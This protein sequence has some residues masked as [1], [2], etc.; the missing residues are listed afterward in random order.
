MQ[1]DQ[2]NGEFPVSDNPESNQ[3]SYDDEADARD[4]R[5]FQVADH[6]IA[7]SPVPPAPARPAHAASSAGAGAAA[8]ANAAAA[9]SSDDDHFTLR[10]FFLWCGVPV[11]IVLLIRIFAVGFY[12]IPSRSMMDTMVPGD[13]VV[14]SKLTPK[15][16]DLQRG[17]VVVFKDPNNWLNEE[18]SS[19]PGGGYL[20][21]RLIGLPGDVVECKGAGQP[22]TINGVA[23]NETSYIRPGVDPSAF[24]FSVTVTEGHVFVMGDNRANS[25]DSRYHQDDG[26]RGLVPISD[27]VESESRNTGRLTG[28][29]RLM[30]TTKSSRTCLTLPARIPESFLNRVSL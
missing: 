10:D 7:L 26:D 21:K 20:I 3:T 15:I 22:V 6:G 16:F 28:L 27:V 23:I 18:Q 2:D 4:S 5:T 14:T 8:G 24:P 1:D 13:R 11:L 29:V 17:D 9:S 30:T 12:E 19:A 25:A